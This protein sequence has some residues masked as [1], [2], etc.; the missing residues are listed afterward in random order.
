MKD[1]HSGGDVIRETEAIEDEHLVI[2]DVIK[3]VVLEVVSLLTRHS[4]CHA[5]VQ[6]RLGQVV[7]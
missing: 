3:Q 7:R 1:D 2:V 5:D 4:I 6:L